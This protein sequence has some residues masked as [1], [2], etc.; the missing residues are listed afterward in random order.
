[1]IRQS[2][3]YLSI[4]AMCV[5]AFTALAAPEGTRVLPS[6]HGFDPLVA[7]GLISTFGTLG[8]GLR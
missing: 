1:M 7:S 2:A 4:T 3:R 5:V 8:F 6:P